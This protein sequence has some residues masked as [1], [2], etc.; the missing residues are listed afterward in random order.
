MAAPTGTVWGDIIKGST[1]PSGRQG[2]IGIYTKVTSTATETE[3][4]VQVWFKTIYSCSDS[5]NNFYYNAGTSISA[6]TTKIGSVSVKH[7]VETGDGWS[8]SNQTK[9]YEKTYKYTR[10]TSEKTYKVYAKFNGID[11]LSGTMYVNTTYTVPALAKYTVTYNA[12]G[13]SGAP[14]SQSKYYGK[15]LPLSSTKPTR[16]GYSFQGWA[17][18]ASGSV[19]YKAGADYTANANVTLYAVWKANTY[20]VS[21]N[22]NGGSGA[23][24]GQTKTYG[25]TLRLSST[26]PTRTNYNFLGWGTAATANTVSYA[27]GANY[28]RNAAITL[29]AIWELAYVKPRIKNIS[30]YRCNS[31]GSAND[32]GAYARV[33][34]DW[35]S[36]RTIAAIVIE[37]SAKGETATNTSV[38]AS[39]TSGSVDKI[40]GAGKLSVEKTYTVRVTVG[41]SVDYSAFVRMLTGYAFVRDFYAQGKGVAWGKPAELENVFDIAF[42]TRLFGG[43]LYPVLEPETDLNEVRTPNTYVGAN[44]SNYNYTNCP[45][46]GGTFTLEVLSAGEEGQVLQRLTRCYKT[47]PTVYERFYYSGTWG[48]WTG[49]WITAELSDKFGAYNGSASHAPK[50]RKDG[51]VVEIR[52]IVTPIVD[53]EYSHDHVKIFTLPEGYRPDIPLYI[54]CQGSGY[55]VWLMRINTNGE[56]GFARYRY[57]ETAATA[58]PE[59]WLPFQATYFAK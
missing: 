54:L 48:E 10:D 4:N 20:T 17:T 35:A 21:Y 30:V 23:P 59:A 50:Y 49:G 34:F 9:L 11:M 37:H 45:I 58:K 24:G 13:G 41:D 12:N 53:L 19:A 16:T 28:T 38:S 32:S 47:D 51:R 7:T 44:V 31:D 42:Q 2:R 18:S 14:S 25:E 15:T 6:A 55:H 22:A 36:D 46:N 8:S 29:Y 56:V 39:G 3:V 5:T 52:G 40:I 33:I 27:A 26:I 43:L 57:G 1:N